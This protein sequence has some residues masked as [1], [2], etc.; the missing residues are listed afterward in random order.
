MNEKAN[1]FIFK[2]IAT[3]VKNKDK[4]VNVFICC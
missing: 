1:F 4:K 2:T 3:N